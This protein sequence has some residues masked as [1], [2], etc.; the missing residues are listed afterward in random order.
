MSGDRVIITMQM[1]EHWNTLPRVAV[2]SPCLE[3]FKNSLD[4][5]LY[6]VLWDKS[7]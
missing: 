2:E 4:A 3:I 1:T 5:I 7:I 6:N